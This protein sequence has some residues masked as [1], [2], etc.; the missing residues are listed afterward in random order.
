VSSAAAESTTTTMDPEL[1]RWARR[2][3][4]WSGQRNLR[5]LSWLVALRWW[6][7][8]TQVVVVVFARLGLALD[9]PIVPVAVVL[10]AQAC[11]NLFTQAYVHRSLRPEA[12]PY[13]VGAQALVGTMFFDVVFLAA[14]LHLTGGYTNPFSFLILVPIALGALVLPLRWAWVLTVFALASL[15]VLFVWYLPLHGIAETRGPHAGHDVAPASPHEHDMILHLQGMWVASAC[16]AAFLVHFVRRVATELAFARDATAR[17]E[18]FAAVA[19][20]AAGAAHE[21]STPLGTI[22]VAA[23]ELERSAGT[24]DDAGSRDALL[25]DV[26]LIRDQVERCRSSLDRLTRDAGAPTAPPPAVL[27]VSDVVRAVLSRVEDERVRLHI[28]PD[29]GSAR[30]EAPEREFVE[31]LAGVV[32]NGLDVTAVGGEVA[33]AVERRGGTIVLS[34]TDTGDGIPREI[35]QRVGEPFFTTKGPS[36]MGLGVFLARGLVEQM[37]GRFEIHS[38]R[39]QGT[40]VVVRLPVA[41]SGSNATSL[42]GTLSDSLGSVWTHNSQRARI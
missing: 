38:K 33:L 3:G 13:A 8:A 24:L 12:G 7:I 18:R 25:A 35:L 5:H 42:G 23:K 1:V 31:A 27:C 26:A 10:V 32:R 29:A 2:G 39:G 15:L 37:G 30:V 9:I 34:I 11:A 16:A 36:G 22:A 20:L 40:R 17:A 4:A 41:A 21:L 14:M 6:A 28:A 19:T